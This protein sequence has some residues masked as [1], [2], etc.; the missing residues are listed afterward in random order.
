MIRGAKYNTLSSS[1][2]FFIFTQCR[3][4]VLTPHMWAVYDFVCSIPH[5]RVCTYKDVCVAI[6]QGSPRS[7]LYSFKHMLTILLILKLSKVGSAL[8]RNPFAPVVPC[9][10]VIASNLF[11][12]GYLGSW[13]IED[14]GSANTECHGW[15]KIDLL[16]G[17]GVE[18][19][20]AGYL[21]QANAVLWRNV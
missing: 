16:R 20:S 18:F 2:V 14:A 5:G 21:L 19:D 13:G 8:R 7:G 1:H 12:G 3:Y 4:Q 6:G 11:L 15:K 17:E 9:H 10:R